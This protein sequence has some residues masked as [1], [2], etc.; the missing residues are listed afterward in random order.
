MF[1]EQTAD[2][3]C[4]RLRNNPNAT[5]QDWEDQLKEIAQISTVQVMKPTYLPSPSWIEY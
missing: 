3:S 5:E 1:V 4:V 2:G